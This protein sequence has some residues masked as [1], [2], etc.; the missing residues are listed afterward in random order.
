[1]DTDIFLNSCDDV[2]FI[3]SVLR[4]ISGS[5]EVHR[6]SE[7]WVHKIDNW[8][9][10]K[11]MGFSGK[12]L[13]ALGVWKE[14]L[15]I[16][17]FVAG[18][19]VGDWYFRYDAISSEYVLSHV[20]RKIHHQGLSAENFRRRVNR[21]A[22]S[23]AFYWFSGNSLETGRGSLMAYIPVESDQEETFIPSRRGREP[24]DITRNRD[25]RNHWCWFVAFTKTEIW[26]I[27]RLKNIHA[28]EVR[29]FDNK[30][31]NI[32]IIDE[33]RSVEPDMGVGS[34]R[35][36]AKHATNACD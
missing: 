20:E 2:D 16:P 4:L 8:F 13:G 15:T 27:N 5:V 22:S 7:F 25:E 24:K 33:P 12:A 26:K 14:P 3:E 9:D 10:H 1:M 29:L 6:P 18:R 17:P 23:A 28:Y 21:L 35:S 19:I 11:W 34:D 30:Y 36:N 31:R 32:H